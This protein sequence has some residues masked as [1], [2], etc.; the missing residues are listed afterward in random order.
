MLT[1]GCQAYKCGLD[2]KSSEILL[3]SLWGALAEILIRSRR[4]YFVVARWIKWHTQIP[5]DRKK[6]GTMSHRQ[7]F[8]DM[9]K[10]TRIERLHRRINQP[11]RHP[12]NPILKGENLWEKMAS[13]YG[14]VLRD[15]FDGQFKISRQRD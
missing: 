4:G 7:L 6:E 11:V 10:V 15:P 9:R 13:L 2:L 1:S 12:E 14:T 5:C 8:L 3:S